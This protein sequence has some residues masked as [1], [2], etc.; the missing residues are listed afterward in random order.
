MTLDIQS[1]PAGRALLL[2][3]A[4][5]V[6]WA[7]QAQPQPQPQAADPLRGVPAADPSAAV[8]P[9]VYTSPL[10]RYRPLGETQ[11]GNWK[12]ANDTVTRIG[13]WRTYAREAQADAPG[14]AA[15]SAASGAASAAAPASAPAAAPAVPP[16][17]S[18]HRR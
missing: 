6:P 4:L 2:A 3:A 1:P 13:G 18:G 16:A 10:R 12:D 14:Q 11:V 17:H 5:V 8:P 7:A 15:S 9:L